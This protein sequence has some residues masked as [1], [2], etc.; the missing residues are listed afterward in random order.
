MSASPQCEIQIKALKKL[1]LSALRQKWVELFKTLPSKSAR[2]DYLIRAIAYHL[3]VKELGGL[4]PGSAKRLKQAVQDYKA[5]SEVA[6]KPKPLINIL[7]PGARLLREW[8][9]RTHEV[10]VL[11]QGFQY[12]GEKH[13]SLS[14]IARKITGT[15][16]SGPRFF[17]LE[18]SK[19]N[20]AYPPDKSGP[21]FIVDLNRGCAHGL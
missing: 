10:L 19:S 2:S 18:A 13:Q 12:R 3:Q 7:H 6:L 4:S 17:G 11:E 5:T 15:H 21:A 1:S 14:V 9:G 16:W 8:Q 20:A